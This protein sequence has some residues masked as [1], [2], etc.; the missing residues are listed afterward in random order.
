MVGEE[1][2]SASL[3]F[4]FFPLYY[5]DESLAIFF[6]LRVT[7]EYIYLSLSFLIECLLS[8]KKNAKSLFSL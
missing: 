8:A 1:N 4:T 3:T 5:M 7:Q 2:K 6:F